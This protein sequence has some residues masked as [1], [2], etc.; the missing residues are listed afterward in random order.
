MGDTDSPIVAGSEFVH[1]FGKLL[2]VGFAPLVVLFGGGK[3]QFES[4]SIYTNS[5]SVFII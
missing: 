5:E 3:S 1:P 2:T 4:S